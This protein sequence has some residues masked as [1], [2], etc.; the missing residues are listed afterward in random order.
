VNEWLQYQRV[1]KFGRYFPKKYKREGLVKLGDIQFG[2]VEER[3][4]DINAS[5]PFK[6]CN[7]ADFIDN[8]GYFDL[9]KFIGHNSQLFPF[10]YK[11]L[12]R[13]IDESERGG[14]QKVLQYC[15]I[16]LG[17]IGGLQKVLQYCRIRLEPKTYKSQGTTL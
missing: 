14:L 5:Y 13:S 15:R 4:D 8:K 1:V 16:R 3:G 17:F 12:L 6:K 11:L 10:I 7:L 2:I 9:V